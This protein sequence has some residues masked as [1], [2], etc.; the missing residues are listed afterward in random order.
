VDRT[1]DLFRQLGGH[2]QWHSLR[3]LEKA[4]K[5]RGIRLALLDPEKLAAQLVAQHADVKR[6]QLI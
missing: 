4:L 6:R 1:D 5:R 3:E 2:F